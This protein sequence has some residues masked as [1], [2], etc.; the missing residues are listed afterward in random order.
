MRDVFEIDLPAL[1]LE[2]QEALPAD[3]R[4]LILARAFQEHVV[5]VLR[6]GRRGAQVE[7][8]LVAGRR[9]LESPR[10]DRCDREDRVVRGRHGERDGQNDG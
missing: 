4:A 2:P 5:R 1:R 8:Q 7:P 9:A 3:V 6:V 10:K